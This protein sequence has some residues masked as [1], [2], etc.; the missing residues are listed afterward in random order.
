MRQ[1]G[2]IIII[3]TSTMT[4]E[5]RR[6]DAYADMNDDDVFPGCRVDIG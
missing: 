5:V 6:F 2:M 1:V 3:T 4:P